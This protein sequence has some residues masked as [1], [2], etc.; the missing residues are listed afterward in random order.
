MLG[1]DYLIL[2][3]WG[4]I[5]KE[6]FGF[7]T[8]QFCDRCNVDALWELCIITSWF[9]I[10]WIPIFPYKKRYCL[11]CNNCT[12]EIN[13]TKNQFGVIFEKQPNYKTLKRKMRIKNIIKIS[14][15]LIVVVTIYSDYRRHIENTYTDNRY[16]YEYN[17]TTS[18]DTFN[19]EL[20][21]RV[22][23]HIEANGFTVKQN[24]ESLRSQ[25]T[26]NTVYGWNVEN[27]DNDVYLVAYVYDTDDNY[28]NGVY[29]YGFEYNTINDEIS[30]VNDKLKQKYIDLDRFK[31]VN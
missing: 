16:N 19:D 27:I 9:T 22:S 11:I 26:F 14:L 28:E 21:D 13:L 18:D 17:N 30:V 7:V 2:W 5:K 6:S 15:V 20:I 10:F 8:Q 25:D 23:K 24:L 31:I 3:G 1:I 12:E 4:R 29:A